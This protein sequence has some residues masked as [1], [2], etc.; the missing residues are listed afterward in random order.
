MDSVGSKVA[1]GIIATLLVMIF[2]GIVILL[3]PYSLCAIA[4]V[5][6]VVFGVA[7]Q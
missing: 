7:V 2:I 5:G 1:W 3:L 6:M 4:L